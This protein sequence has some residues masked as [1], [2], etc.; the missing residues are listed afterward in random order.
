MRFKQFLEM[1]VNTAELVGKGW[2]KFPDGKAMNQNWDKASH[3]ILTNGGLERVRKSWSK[4]PQDFDL[5]FVKDDGMRKTWFEGEVSENHLKQRGI[6]VNINPNAITLIFTNN[7]GGNR[8]PMTP[9]ILGHRFGHVLWRDDEFQGF[10]KM[11]RRDFSDLIEEIY[12][13]ERKGGFMAYGDSYDSEHDK[14]LRLM[15]M[16]LGSM[17]SART[18]KLDSFEEFLFEMLGQYI[19]AGKIEFRNNVPRMLT[20]RKAW[21]R[22]ADGVYSKIHN[23]EHMMDYITQ[24]LESHAHHYTIQC[25]RIL[26][27]CVG[28]IF[29]I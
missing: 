5:F 4:V 15:A 29:V 27:D 7:L 14:L 13:R 19:I 22:H 9:W 28:R 3:N 23:D 21:G 20:T 17:R 6:N 16:A 26:N 1:P 2:G 25:K 12:G 11:V 10:Y 18:G 24:A 8:V